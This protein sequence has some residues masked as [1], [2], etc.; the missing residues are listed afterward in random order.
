ML[1]F[2]V[3][4]FLQPLLQAT[5]DR[6]SDTGN[7]AEKMKEAFHFWPFDGTFCALAGNP[8]FIDRMRRVQAA[9]NHQFVAGRVGV[10]PAA[11]G[12]LPSANRSVEGKPMDR[13]ANLSLRNTGDSQNAWHSRLR[14]CQSA[15]FSIKPACARASQGSCG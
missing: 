13:L 7:L 8:S 9:I 15:L 5:S 1:P 14:A 6:L 3:R 12:I 2:G 4:T 11:E 10:S